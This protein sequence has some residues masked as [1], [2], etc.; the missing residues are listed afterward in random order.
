VRD[1][2]KG[3]GGVGRKRAPIGACFP[4][5]RR[6]ARRHGFPPPA[7]EL[8]LVGDLLLDRRFQ[9]RP[10]LHLLRVVDDRVGLGI[11]DL[12][13]LRPERPRQLAFDRDDLARPRVDELHRCGFLWRCR[14]RGVT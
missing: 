13:L 6:L 5:A 1:A 2:G 3:L 7:D 4:A 12:R 8:D 9:R 14:F 11:P 10:V